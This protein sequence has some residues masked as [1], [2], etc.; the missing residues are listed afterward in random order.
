[1][2]GLIV[3]FLIVALIA[4]AFGFG[5]IAGVAMG[6]AQVLFF[7]FIV[8]FLIALIFAIVRGDRRWWWW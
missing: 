8:L 3:I 6:F 4:A 5:G 2:L 7:I 1:M